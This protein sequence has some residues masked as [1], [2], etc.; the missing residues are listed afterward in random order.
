M[1][2]INRCRI[3]LYCCIFFLIGT[4][5]QGMAAHQ[6]SELSSTDTISRH[7]RGVMMINDGRLGAGMALL[8][9]EQLH[10]SEDSLLTNNIQKLRDVRI[11]RVQSPQWWLYLV[12]MH[13]FISHNATAGI[14]FILIVLFIA[15]RN[16]T[17]LKIPGIVAGRMITGICCFAA[18]AVF[19]ISF[20]VVLG[21]DLAVVSAQKVVVYPGPDVV[22]DHQYYVHDGL[23]CR[24]IRRVDGWLYV[25]FAHGLS[26]WILEDR[27]DFV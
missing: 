15:I 10:R 12:D 18:I 25:E 4:H 14:A 13:R 21:L 17:S 24:V 6:P 11:D 5:F 3:L 8:L 27:V 23:E 22:L 7:A 19:M 16:I 1:I 26:G 9:Q 20:W 2:T